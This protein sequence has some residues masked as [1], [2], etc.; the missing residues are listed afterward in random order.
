MAQGKKYDDKI[1]EQAFALLSTGNTASFVANKLGLKY[2]TVKTWEKKWK[3][4]GPDNDGLEELRRRKKETFVQSAWDIM[5]GA[6]SLIQ[7]RV[8]RALFDED[9]LDKLLDEI[10]NLTLTDEERRRLYSRF[11]ALKLE[12]V[13]ELATV[14]GTLYDKQ[15]LANKEAT[16]NVGGEL[17]FRKFEDIPE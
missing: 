3:E 16:V 6:T 10:D 13:R 11:S 15:A 2:T 12:N 7:R 17:S 14:L 8:N 4:E 5:D 1:R 9:K